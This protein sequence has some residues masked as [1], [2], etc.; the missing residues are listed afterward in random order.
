[1]TKQSTTIKVGSCAHSH[2]TVFSFH[3]VKIITTGEGGMAMTIDPALANRMR[4]LRTHGNTSDKELMYPRPDNEI[5][6][7]QQI[8]L[9]FNYRMTDIQA[10]LGLSQMQRLDEFVIRRHEI[11]ERYDVELSSLPITTPHQAPG[12][13][14]SY[15][16][17]PIRVSE[18]ESGKTQRQV[19]DAL[20]QNGV[21][22]NLHY[23]PVHRQPYYEKLGFKAGD[24]PEAE[25][26]H[27]EAISIPMHPTLDPQQQTAVIAALAKVLNS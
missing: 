23:I 13:Y 9:G 20:W 12:T 27:R 19:Y 14:S 11:A 4:R 2:I 17:Y 18:A 8:E 10:A 24:F 3:P 25:Q 16:L 21:A 1:M 26:F 5:W 22:A 6:N 7:Y 15:H